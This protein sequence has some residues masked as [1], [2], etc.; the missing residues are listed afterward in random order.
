MFD[1]QLHK[2]VT[3]AKLFNLFFNVCEHL[4]PSIRLDCFDRTFCQP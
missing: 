4:A 3:E 2:Q 1:L